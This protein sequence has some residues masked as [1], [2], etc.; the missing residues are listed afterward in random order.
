MINPLPVTHNL[1]HVMRLESKSHSRSSHWQWVMALAGT[2]LTLPGAPL[3]FDSAAHADEQPSGA[4]RV[5]GRIS[6]RVVR[7]QGGAPVAGAEVT[8]LLPPA[9]RRDSYVWPLPVRNAQT[10]GQGNFSFENLPAGKY[11]VWA[12]HEKLTSRRDTLRGESVVIPEL[13]EQPKPLELRMLAG[14][15]VTAI[16]KN[17]ASG[18]AIPKAIVHFGWSDLQEDN[19]ATD[20][21]GR[22]T[23]QSL[24]P[25]RWFIQAW[26]D[27]F[28]SQSQW[29]NL[30]SESDG[31]VDFLLGPGG[32]I[33]GVIRDP[34]GKPVADVGLSVHAEGSAQQLLYVKTND[35]GRYRL[36][37]LPL[38]IPFEITLSKK[39]YLVETAT[40]RASD[41]KKTHDLIILP[42]PHGGSIVGTVVD[43]EGR[44][45]V[46]AELTNMGLSSN[47]L[48]QT[49]TDKDGRFRLENLYAGL[50]G[51]EITIRAKKFAPLRFKVK[52]GPADEPVK[53]DIALDKGHTLKGRVK[54]EAGRPLEGVS[55]YFGD[56]GKNPFSDGGQTQ[57][58]K[59]GRF[60]FD[61][62]PPDCPFT[63]MKLG[64]S[65]IAERK[66][67]LD[68]P[69]VIAVTMSP[70]GAIQGKVVDITSGKPIRA[71]NVR[72]TFSPI[73][74]PNDPSTGIDGNLIDPGQAF[75]SE[76]GIFKIGNLLL[77][78][79]LQV[80][81]DAEGYEREV[82]ERIVA[83]RPDQVEPV[84]FKLAPIDPA[85]LTTYGGQLRDTHGNPVA[86][87]ILRLIAA[88]NRKHGPNDWQM[89][90]SGQLAQQS[91]VVRFLEGK[92]NAAGRFEF[93]RI[94]KDAEVELLWWGPGIAS[95]L[96]NH[97]ETLDDKDRGTIEIDL[98]APATIKVTID[99]DALPAIGQVNIL[100]QNA[101]NEHR[102]LV[103]KPGQ[104]SFEVADLAP[105]GY[106]VQVM[107][108]YEPVPGSPGQ[109]T[110]KILAQ[111][112]VTVGAGETGEVE[113]N[114]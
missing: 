33:E 105:G 90:R 51:P 69:D 66:F 48:C 28:A 65:Q 19:F 11:R 49:T 44:P 97:L 23:L 25:Q 80:M 68:T 94:P 34:L 85:S 14:V 1:E 54:D 61:S 36:N 96:S 109:L 111:A 27:G 86:G 110:S 58:D 56:A 30:E 8:L 62:L 104:K 114:P 76:L 16:V 22:V 108:P 5:A 106:I 46:G 26:A 73:R 64:F 70:T 52:P 47:D 107:G 102:Q 18:Q 43:Q 78:M 77:G 71:F 100:S 99:R 72:I 12:N 24:T 79:P 17:Q 31:E 37:H 53:F 60:E 92:T 112:T 67:H 29:L 32:I 98:P 45:I 84:E 83:D 87:A 74:E 40:V 35:Q 20:E 42:R 75:Q 39:D 2:V 57:T 55:V 95:G 21:D 41:P 59:Q 7:D 63:F 88:R 3:T 101:A 93:P 10:D 15:A 81:V 50:S 6:G 38:D 4:N 9:Q 13:G 91:E 103:P 82:W 113:F 89:I